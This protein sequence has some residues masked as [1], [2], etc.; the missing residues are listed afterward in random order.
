MPEM[1]HISYQS[2]RLAETNVLIPIPRLISFWSK[3]I[4]KWR[5]V[6]SGDLIWPFDGWAMQIFT[7][8]VLNCPIRYDSTQMGLRRSKYNRVDFLFIDLQWGG[9]KNDLTWGHR[10]K[11]IRDISFVGTDD[12]IFRKFHNFLWNIVAVAR[13]ESYFVV[14]SLDL[15]WWPDL[16]WPW[17]E[18]FTTVAENMGG[19]VGENPYFRYPW[20][21][22]GVVQTPPPPPPPSRARVN[23]QHKL[24]FVTSFD[25]SHCIL[26]FRYNCGAQV[27]Q[28]FCYKVFSYGYSLTEF[29]FN[30]E[31]GQVEMETK[32]EWL[33]KLWSSRKRILNKQ[34]DER[35]WTP[36]ILKIRG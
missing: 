15:S 19:K 18:I 29:L 23:V 30:A 13:L 34:M 35:H 27:M 21:T 17:V 11:K 4:G 33:Y 7:Q 5:L 25:D 22:W 8:I 2:I 9:R 1:S 24:S 31:Q 32:K 12:I 28:W 3:V 26:L 36:L 20:K 14:G 6:T 10:Y 16:T